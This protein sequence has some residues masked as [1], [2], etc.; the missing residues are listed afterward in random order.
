MEHCEFCNMCIVA[1]S[2]HTLNGSVSLNNVIQ[3]IHALIF[4][5]LHPRQPA[6]DFLWARFVTNLCVL[7]LDDVLPSFNDSRADISRA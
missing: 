1:D 2:R 6:L 5:R 7:D 3:H 4:L